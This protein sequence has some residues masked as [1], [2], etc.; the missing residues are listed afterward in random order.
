MTA[1]TFVVIR[2]AGWFDPRTEHRMWQAVA[3]AYGIEL[4]LVGAW[5]EAEIDAGAELILVDEEGTELLAEHAPPAAATYVFG[6]TSQ[7]L[8]P[9]I[10]E[11][12]GSIRI[13]VPHQRHSLFAI[14]AGS[15]VAEHLRGAS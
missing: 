1:A 5:P 7:R 14:S 3:R 10:P 8:L 9:K 2:D 12:T 11:A 6:R 4:Q 13:P 15:I